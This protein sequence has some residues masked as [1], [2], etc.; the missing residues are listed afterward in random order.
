M[1]NKEIQKSRMWK[2]FVDATAEIIQ[3]EGIEKV[4]IRKVADRAGYN[5]ATIYN[6][7][8]EVSHLIFFASM[9]FLKTYTDDVAKYM[10]KGK[11]PIEK[12]VLAWECFC[13]HSFKQPKIFQ[14][15][16]IMD[17]G[18]HP[19][20]M[21]ANYYKI[22]PNDLINIP[23]ELKPILFKRNVSKRGRSVL[24]IA[25]KEGYIKEESIDAVNEMTI[26]IWQ[27][28]FTN[29]L[30]HRSNYEPEEAVRITM[31]YISDIVRNVDALVFKNT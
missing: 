12:Y 30:N 9:K 23:D 5:S 7:F 3:E 22:F 17:L 16:F 20:N 26:L 19:E 6:Y 25:M 11:N 29:I 21:L 28:M 13:T 1:N 18:D 27:G 4:T 31:K 8:S 24:E 14:A 2:Y 15:V 10:E